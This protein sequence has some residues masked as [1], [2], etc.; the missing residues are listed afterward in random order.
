MKETQNQQLGEEKLTK[1]RKMWINL[2]KEVF[3]SLDL[4]EDIDTFRLIL[5]NYNI[6]KQENRKKLRK[7]ILEQLG[8]ENNQ[9]FQ[10]K[11]ESENEVS[12][13]KE[14]EN[15]ESK[16]EETKI[17]VKNKKGKIKYWIDCILE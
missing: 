9:E 14:S 5:Q 2:S 13:N 8:E 12:E 1:M 16:N 11:E 15:L 17:N 6:L 7:D 4:K 10:Y 3:L